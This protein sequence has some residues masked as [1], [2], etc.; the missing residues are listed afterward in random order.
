MEKSY[1]KSP[2][3]VL[4]IICEKDALI[5]LKLV[6]KVDKSDNETVLIKEVR[7]QLNEYFSG[8][9]KIFDIK[10]NPQGT[11]FQ[12]LVW[13]EL[14]KIQ[15]GKTKSYSEIAVA[16]GNKNAQ[17]AVGSACNKNPILII[18]P[19][20][21][22]IS[23]NGSLGGFEYG[24]NIKEKLLNLE[25]K[26]KN[27][28]KSFAPSIDNNSHI[29]ILGSMPGVKSLEEQQYYAHPQNRFWKVMGA[30]CNE[31]KLH[32]F[33]YDL[34]LKTLLKNNIA[35]WD[36]IKSCKRE[37]SLDSDIQNETPND[38]RKLL[39]KYPYIKTICLNGNKSYSAFKKYFPDL[40]EKY[41]CYKMPST[42]PANARYS[43]DK[44]ITDWNNFSSLLD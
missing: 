35:L 23:K 38:I 28:C 21:R 41:N 27:E 16:A 34:K 6:K 18:I 19:C 43:L 17:R 42:S 13:K 22:V 29:L 33:D 15:Y 36:T 31:P 3:G 2:I 44:L 20:H 10:I 40:L 5:S 30:I 9:R 12:K 37:G 4:E 24:I 26:T 1:Y 32:E 8:K 14:Q 11:K 7:T 39:K 25:N